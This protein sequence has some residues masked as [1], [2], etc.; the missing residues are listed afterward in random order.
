[1]ITAWRSAFGDEQMPFCIISLCTAGDPQTREN[2]S[3]SMRDAGAMIREAQYRTFRDFRAA[4][5]E[6]IGFASSFDFRKKWYHPQIK[7]P[8]GERAAKWA[9]ATKYGLLTGRDAEQYW[10]PP[11]IEEVEVSDGTIRLTMSTQIT[12]KDESESGMTGFAIAG[13]DRRFH[14]AEIRYFTDGTVDNRNRPKFQ[15]DI[16]V[17]S[18]PLVP[19]PVHYR[20]AWARN[21]MANLTNSRQIPIATQRS[22]DWLMEETPIKFPLPPGADLKSMSRQIS[23]K[24]SK[25]LELQDRERRIVEAEA[26]VAE[27]KEK[28]LADK[29]AWEESKAKEAERVRAMHKEAP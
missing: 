9:L 18:S 28:F 11:S 21:P 10:L 15:R 4:G 27:L 3:A 25:E 8:A 5:D 1:M 6:T 22:D 12:M 19:E 23:G 24:I 20:Y 13:K 2:F 14:P 7:V 26:T 29:K 16:L 17:L